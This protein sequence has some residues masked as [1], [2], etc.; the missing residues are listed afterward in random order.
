MWLGYPPVLLCNGMRKRS[1][2][3]Q[4]TRLAAE[5]LNNYLHVAVGSPEAASPTVAHH[6][7]L[8]T[9]AQ[10]LDLVTDQLRSLLGD[11]SMDGEEPSGDGGQGLVVLFA[12][13]RARAETVHRHLQASGFGVIMLHNGNTQVSLNILQQ[14][15]MRLPFCILCIPAICIVC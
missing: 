14:P 7:Q 1:D 2:V 10:K 11:A 8:A 9:Q 3:P 12:R 13:T 5:L 15:F 4:V 6:L